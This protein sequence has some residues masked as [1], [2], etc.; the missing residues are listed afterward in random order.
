MAEYLIIA[1]KPSLAGEVAAAYGEHVG[2]KPRKNGGYWEV[3]NAQV[4]WLFGH[5]YD[6]A[7]P[8]VY[9]PRYK[10]WNLA[11][12]P[13]IP[14]TW[15]LL[16]Y[17][18]KKDHIAVIAKL[19]KSAKN[20]V[21]AGDAARE[22]QLLVDEL[23][24]ENGWDPF[25]A[26]TFRLWVRSVARQDLLAAIRGMFPN[27]EKRNLFESALC[28][29]R[30][31]WL[32]GMNMSRLFTKLAG[33][34]GAQDVLIS[35]GRV[36]T[37]TLKLVVDRD[38]EIENFKPVDHYKPKIT[39]AH[40]N[41]KFVATWIIPSDGEGIDP[42]GRLLDKAIAERIIAKVD[43]K[44]G[45][46]AEY[47]AQPKTTA[48]PLPYNLSSLQTACSSQ[49]SLTAAQTLEVAQRL[50][51]QKI[52]TYPRS[53]SRYLPAAILTDEA[54]GIVKN[55]KGVD[56]LAD[57]SE[58]A[59]L[60][61][62]SAAWN[63]AKVS[64]HH[65]IIPTAEATPGKISQ[66]S[67][68]ERKVF[69]LIACTFLAQFYPGMRYK[70]VSATVEVEKERFK[71]NGKELVDIGWKKVFGAEGPEEDEAPDAEDETTI[72]KM[73]SKDPVTA[74]AGR[75]D[76]KRTT[77]P[78]RFN[79]GTL[80]AAMSQIHKFVPNPEIKKRLRENDGL[81]T[82][83]TRAATIEILVSERRKY[84]VRQGKKNIVST[85]LGRS[86]IQSLPAEI[87]DPGLT[88]LWEGY[89][90]RVASGEL[91]PEQ[92]MDAQVKQLRKRVDAAKGGRFEVK[93]AQKIELLKGHGEQCPTCK[94][95]RLVTRVIRKGEH[96]GKRFLSCERY[97]E[98]KHVQ[99]PDKPPVEPMDGHGEPCPK[100]KDGQMV[101]RM[102]GKGDNKGK[103][104][105]SCNKYP[106]CKHSSFPKP[107]PLPGEGK[108]CGKCNQG[109]M[110]TRSGKN[111]AFLACDR[112]PECKN[113][114][115]PN[116][117]K[118]GGDGQKRRVKKPN[119]K[120]LSRFE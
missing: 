36:Q 16:P 75:V 71:A 10:S 85:K 80:I 4:T 111:G 117:G 25:S 50:Y 48:P 49:F 72:P 68:V 38:L 7:P 83:A 115:N 15:K 32:H 9:N 11:D 13:I 118:G 20:V 59:N 52:T 74:E 62:K 8:P 108:K 31:D 120:G 86:I 107:D 98:C 35:V 78:P 114:E 30:A 61:L 57:A 97:P 110:K 92:F 99:W 54:P 5:M 76:A 105:L 41:G 22:G 58:N 37:P 89:L 1:E 43:G 88:A 113:T 56:D 119:A 19:L 55:L 109:T 28:R 33:D 51:D 70:S 63:D 94:E 66:L 2:A 102:V 101:T 6:Q 96:K 27:A 116:G 100:C 112:F 42:D 87:T 79:D 95:G 45:H 53:D 67:G 60:K 47:K 104:F 18:D 34:A 39:F 40:E 24:I 21:N 3:G 14:D 12:L 82:E 103:R 29:S 84:L 65:A 64:D 91:P 46:V 44:T 77:P 81:G 26:N 73:T 93:G 106:E 90:D 23:L 17:K 69:M